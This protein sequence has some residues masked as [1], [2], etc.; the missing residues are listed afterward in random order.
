MELIRITDSHDP[1]LIGV[2]ALY[3]SAFPSVARIPS[4]KLLQLIDQ[5]P[6]MKFNIIT[7]RGKF[8]GM[9][10]VWDLDKFRYLEYF[11]MLPHF[12]C[13]GIGTEVLGELCRQSSQPIVAEVEPPE[14]DIQRRRIAFYRRNGFHVHSQHPSI[15]NGFHKDNP[16]WLIASQP[17]Q[18]SDACQHE[19]IRAVYSRVLHSLNT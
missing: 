9:A 18:D 4:E 16:L 14:S 19:I 10:I 3:E 6:Q 8:C 5:Y 12:R 11:A 13:Q 17:L 2:P 7:V 15:L 1:L